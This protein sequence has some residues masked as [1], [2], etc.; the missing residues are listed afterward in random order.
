MQRLFHRSSCMW[1]LGM[2]RVL[3]RCRR[4]SSFLCFFSRGFFWFLPTIPWSVFL[5]GGHIPFLLEPFSPPFLFF[6]V[7]FF[8]SLICL[9]PLAYFSFPVSRTSKQTSTLLPWINPVPHVC[10]SLL[11]SPLGAIR[12]LAPSLNF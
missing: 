6:A 5:G 4:C 8:L 12:L 11:S 9:I 1:I 10:F 7:S 2:R 3:L